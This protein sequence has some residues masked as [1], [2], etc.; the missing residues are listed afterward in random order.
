MLHIEVHVAGNEEVDVAVAVIIRP[1]RA[2]A[3][4]AAA[5]AGLVGH[6]LENAFPLIAIENIGAVAGDVKIEIAVVVVV[7]HG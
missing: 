2:R 7:G 4:P 6:I 1:R 3:E 5:H